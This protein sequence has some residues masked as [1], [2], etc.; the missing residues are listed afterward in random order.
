M[1]SFKRA[2]ELATAMEARGYDPT[3][4]RS[5][6]HRL[7]WERRDSWAALSI[8]MIALILIGLRIVF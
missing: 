2:E 8:V 4:P 7:I 6:Y 3:A 1:N 5:H